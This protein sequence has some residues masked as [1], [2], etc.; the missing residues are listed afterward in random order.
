MKKRRLEA[1]RRLWAQ[2]PEETKIRLLAL[3]LNQI[4]EACND[5]VSDQLNKKD[6]GQ[7]RSGEVVGDSIISILL[8]LASRRS[9]SDVRPCRKGILRKGG[10][11]HQ[12]QMCQIFWRRFHWIFWNKSCS[13]ILNYPRMSASLDDGRNVPVLWNMCPSKA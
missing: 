10:V 5:D 9:Q 6:S 2:P 13:W 1:F 11:V 8:T 7:R 4:S 12:G 3:H